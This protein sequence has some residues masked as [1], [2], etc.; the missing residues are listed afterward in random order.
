MAFLGI[1]IPHETGR[2]LAGIDVPGN[3][4]G[5]SEYHITLLCFE[6]N[7]PISEIS[8]AL[9]ATYEIV[10]NIKPFMVSVDEIT[11]FP[12]REDNPVPIIAKVKSAE[13]HELRDKLA[14]NFDKKKID[15]SKIFKDFKPHITL[16]YAD[17][18]MDDFEIDPVEFMIQE[19]VL[20]GGDH[21]DDRIFV[22]F[23]LKGPEKQK[24]ALL[25]Q[26]V[27][28]FSKMANNPPQD[29]LTQSYERRKIER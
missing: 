9:E 25:L 10:S 1:R 12:K 20:W 19:L 2:L 17:E 13:L 28:I 16:A 6:E 11:C 14:K 15:F 5:S 3:K 29:Y 27:D 7:W 23:P 22:T 21:G 18:E 24:H 26:K 4:E 8:K